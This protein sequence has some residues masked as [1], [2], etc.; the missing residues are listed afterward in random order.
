MYIQI[1]D[2]S[3]KKNTK[4][5][6]FSFSGESCENC[7]IDIAMYLTLVSDIIIEESYINIAMY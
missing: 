5:K 2:S 1:L 4:K 7:K 3:R 6:H